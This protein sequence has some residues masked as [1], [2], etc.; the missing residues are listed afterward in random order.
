MAD[1]GGQ[2]HKLIR[3]RSTVTVWHGYCGILTGTC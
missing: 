2:L 3:L 1:G